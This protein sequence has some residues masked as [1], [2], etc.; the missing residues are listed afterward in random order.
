MAGYS[1]ARNRATQKYVK[2]NYDTIVFRMR[3][4]GDLNKDALQELAKTSG[5]A[6]NE[7]ITKAILQRAEAEKIPK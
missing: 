3:K 7:Y 5:E 4:D 6:V 2:N 1:E